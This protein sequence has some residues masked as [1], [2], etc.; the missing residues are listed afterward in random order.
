[1]QKKERVKLLEKCRK[2]HEKEIRR[3]KRYDDGLFLISALLA[4]AW[5]FVGAGTR[6]L[7]TF[8]VLLLFLVHSAFK[9][10]IKELEQCFEVM[11]E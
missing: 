4:A 6:T 1:M 7:I 3:L 10:R 9:S 11:R 8:V 5:F 2:K